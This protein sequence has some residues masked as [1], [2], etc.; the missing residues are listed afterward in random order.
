MKLTWLTVSVYYI[1]LSFCFI[2]ICLCR[3][4][5]DP[6]KKKNSHSQK[7]LYKFFAKIDL[8]KCTKF[9]SPSSL[10]CFHFWKEKNNKQ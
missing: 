2:R 1:A 9:F 8:C 4:K 5:K 6:N 10:C 3:E 7:N